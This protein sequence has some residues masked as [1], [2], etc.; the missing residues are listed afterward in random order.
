MDMNRPELPNDIYDK[1]IEFQII[2]WWCSDKDTEEND[3]DDS[4]EQASCKEYVM[5]CFGATKQGFSVGCE[6][7]GFQPFYYVKVDKDWNNTK[8]RKFI[9][10]VEGYYF[11]QKNPGSLIKNKCTF[12]EKKDVYGFTNG[13]YYRFVKLTFSSYEAMS[14]SKYIFKNPITIQGIHTKSKKYKLYESN[15]EPFMRFAHIKDIK[16][17]GWIKLPHGKYIE[18]DD[19]A[20]TQIFVSIDRKDIEPVEKNDIAR[21]LQASWDIE[22]YSYD[23]AFP[24]PK[25]KQNVIFQ[26]ATTFKW[27]GDKQTCIKYLFTL[28]H[29]S[30]IDDPYTKV[31]ECEDEKQLLRKWCELIHNSDPDILYTYNGDAFDCM[32]LYERASLL[33]IEKQVLRKLSRST[34][35]TSILKK[36]FFSSSAYGDNEYFRLYIPG[37]LNYD[38]L[39]HYKRGMKK[40]ASYKLD[41]IANEILGVGKNPVSAKQIFSYYK[42]GNP[43]LIRE[44]G[45]YCIVDT[46]LLQQ[47][48]DKQLILLTIIQLAN[49]TYVPIG[50]L[51][52]RGQTIKVFSQVLRKARQM[53]FLVP[54]TNFNEDT[55]A[56]GIQTKEPVFDDSHIGSY[57]EIDLGLSTQNKRVKIN[58]KIDEIVDDTH[59][60][61]LS[62]TEITREYF[63]RTVTF[64][65]NK[66]LAKRVW[67]ADDTIDDT[68]TGATVLQANAGIYLKDNISVLDFAS[69]YPTV[70]ISRNLCFSTLVLDDAY[71][72]IPGV[73]YETIEWDDHRE[74]KLRQTC[75]GVGKTGKSKGQVCGKQAFYEYETKYYCR[76]H[77]PL[78]KSRQ[79]DEKCQKEK[80]H[81]KYVIVQP[82][83]NAENTGVIPSL[84]TELYSERKRVKKLMNK[85]YSENDN[86]LADIMNSTQLA[87][88]VSL[89]SVYGFVSRSK[90]NLIMKPLGQLTTSIGRMLIEQSKEYAEGEFLD[91]VKKSNLATHE[92]RVIDTGNMTKQQKLKLLKNNEL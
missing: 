29:C 87:I 25:N 21:F 23:N 47:L 59:I 69:L 76:I 89:N 54:H 35:C 66:I 46:E 44:I 27:Y 8:L 75:Q 13:E 42:D 19:S 7:T 57:I 24:D 84:L 72:N 39:I 81:Y 60:I 85:A 73:K 65:Y 43:D 71:L 86:N 32:Y 62:S 91:Y 70:E 18:Q 92:I 30:P 80:V 20:N 1:D 6:I 37:R 9:D 64:N 4:S 55:N 74:V 26:I 34:E 78:K 33:G 52:T 83:P 12:V 61:I 41:N 28:K 50:F 3:S 14:R 45:A 22:C 31:V 58:G 10:Y 2:E 53:D 90:G 11:F 67:P 16:M 5:R 36:E 49:V 51:T 40:Y 48:V 82:G 17:A 68:F 15:V 56:I 88:K 38:L 79:D 77:D 63:N